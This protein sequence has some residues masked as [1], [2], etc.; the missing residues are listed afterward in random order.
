MI[1]YS[2]GNNLVIVRVKK[3]YPIKIECNKASKNANWQI[4]FGKKH[5]KISHGKN[6]TP[7][8]FHDFIIN[9]TIHV[10]REPNKE[11]ENHFSRTLFLVTGI[12]MKGQLDPH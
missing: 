3:N 5:G 8:I 2:F 1:L 10:K 6:F 7:K 12:I 9:I 4:F 11:L